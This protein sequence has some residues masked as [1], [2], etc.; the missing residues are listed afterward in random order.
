MEVEALREIANLYR[1]KW[2]GED[3]S[4]ALARSFLSG[5]QTG[6]SR[7]EASEVILERLRLAGAEFT[8]G[9]SEGLATLQKALDE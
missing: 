7:P 4:M 5:L 8:E 1:G 3:F 6:F 2:D 9:S